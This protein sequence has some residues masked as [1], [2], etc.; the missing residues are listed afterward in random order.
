MDNGLN[1]IDY[2][3]GNGCAGH[4]TIA[5]GGTK[6]RRNVYYAVT[7]ST[8]LISLPLVKWNENHHPK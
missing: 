1:S 2:Y 8:T 5:S 6:F 7:H 4:E 3:V